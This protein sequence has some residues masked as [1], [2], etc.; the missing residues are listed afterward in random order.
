MNI[1]GAGSYFERSL[2]RCTTVNVQVLE[3]YRNR[4]RNS[5]RSVVT[6]G[7][8]Y[9]MRSYS[10]NYVGITRTVNAEG[11]NAIKV[12]ACPINVVRRAAATGRAGTRS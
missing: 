4:S 10:G 9:G 2:G 1:A 8:K 5:G 3:E 6:R 12:D 7:I 11:M